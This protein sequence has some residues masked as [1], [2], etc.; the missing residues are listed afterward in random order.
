MAEFTSLADELTGN[1]GTQREKQKSP[2]VTIF[3]VALNIIA[4]S[5]SLNAE[6]AFMRYGALETTKVIEGHEYYRM[7]TS[8]F[9]HADF[10]HLARNMIVL[11]FLGAAVEAYIG[12]TR[13]FI[14]YIVSGIIGNLASLL[15]EW[16]ADEVRLSIGASGAVFGAMGATLVIAFSNRRL[17]RNRSSLGFRVLF[18]IAFSIYAGLV[19]DGVNN[20]AHIGGLIGGLWLAVIFTSRKLDGIN[21]EEWL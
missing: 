6:T 7:V 14:L 10:E 4:F 18:M 5:L 21:K 15:M 1:T 9:L 13:W 12:H 11:F 19:S 20:A 17:L 8:M 16:S 2:M 3:L